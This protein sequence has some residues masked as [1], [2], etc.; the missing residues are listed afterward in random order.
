MERLNSAGGTLPT[1]GAATVPVLQPQA[2]AAACPNGIV[3]DTRSPEAFAGGHVPDAYSVW[4]AGLPVFGGWVADQETAVHLVVEAPRDLEDAV[5][6]LARIGIDRVEGVL[7]NGFDSWRNAGLP[8]AAAGTS[9]P[10]DMQD[11]FGMLTILDVREITEFE[12]GHIPGARHLYVGDLVRHGVDTLGLDPS[13]PLVVT[14]SV[15]HRASLGVSFLQRQGYRHV[16]NLLGGM[17]AWSKLGLP[18]EKAPA[19]G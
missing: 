13:Q 14:C 17:T 15:G 2:F 10:R 3:V 6:H 5:L 19:P 8:I 16:S 12:A 7:A 1:T 9:A 4:L 18:E 11:R